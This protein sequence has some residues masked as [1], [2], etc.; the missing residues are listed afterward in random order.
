MSRSRSVQ[1]RPMPNR[2]YRIREKMFSDNF[3]IKDEADQPVFNVRAR[4]LSFGDKLVLEDMA[5]K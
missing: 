2:R 4:F 1:Y 3:S 5:G